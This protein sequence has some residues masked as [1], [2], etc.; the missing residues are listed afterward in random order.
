MRVLLPVVRPFLKSPEQGAATSVYLASSPEV[1]GVTGR[2][3]VNRRA[4]DSSPASR[5]VAL[6]ARLW[7]VSAQLVGLPGAVHF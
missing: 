4:R 1:D 3:F 7:E 5:D 6:A 2:Y